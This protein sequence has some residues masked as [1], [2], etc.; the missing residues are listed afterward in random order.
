MTEKATFKENGLLTLKGMKKTNALRLLEEQQLLYTTV[1][2][3]YDAENLDV[4]HIAQENQLLLTTIYKT[5]VLTGDKTGVFIALVAG[6]QQLNLKKAAQVSGNKKAVLLP[7]KKIL[8]TTGYIRGGCSPLG[9]KKKYPVYLDASAKHL[10]YIYV[11]AGV[12]GLLVGLN[13]EDLQTATEA[14]WSP[15]S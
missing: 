5:L 10:E 8:A 15:L 1:S 6:D 11:N 13:P 3:T 4:A 14:T 12:R 2:Y 7:V 9:L